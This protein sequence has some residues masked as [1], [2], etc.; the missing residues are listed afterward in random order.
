MLVMVWSTV[1][2]IDIYLKTFAYLGWLMK[3]FFTAKDNWLKNWMSNYVKS[4]TQV[5][6]INKFI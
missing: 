5:F 4:F 1:N 2:R 3:P 6:P